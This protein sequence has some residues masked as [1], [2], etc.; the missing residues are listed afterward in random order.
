MYIFNMNWVIC[1]KMIM[2]C[3][4]YAA[5]DQKQNKKIGEQNNVAEMQYQN[6]MGKSVCTS[7]YVEHC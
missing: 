3:C 6:F 2:R 5:E 7:S 4:G 1:T